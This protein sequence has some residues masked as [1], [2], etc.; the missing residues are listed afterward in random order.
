[1]PVDVVAELL[2]QK[3]VDVTK[4]YSGPTRS[5]VAQSADEY[6]SSVAL[7]L[8]VEEKLTRSPAEL[9]ELYQEAQ[10]K[11]GTL[12][13]VIGGVCVSHGY[14][15]TKFECIGCAGK[16]PDPTKRSQVIRKL[17]WAKGEV[18]YAT[19]EGLLP[20]AARMRRLVEDCK[21]E[22]REMD[23]MEECES[24]EKNEQPSISIDYR[25]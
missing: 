20:E 25:T 8:D 7:D 15:Q 13:E 19:N 3:N 9:Q 1:M 18:G 5:M 17:D 10:G 24:D 16:V 4:Y 14:C 22:L 12:S 21:L 2:H 11:A 6:L 23:L